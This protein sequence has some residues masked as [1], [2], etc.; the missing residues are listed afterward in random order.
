MGDLPAQ[1]RNRDFF[2]YGF[3]AVEDACGRPIAGRVLMHLNAAFG[4]P[5]RH[6]AEL[7]PVLGGR[8]IRQS[9]RGSVIDA[10]GQRLPDATITEHI[11]T[12]IHWREHRQ[13]LEIVKR[14]LAVRG[15]MERD[16]QR[17]FALRP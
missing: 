17:H 14:I 1:A 7:L 15:N 4:R 3:E 9:D 6:G 13:R 16:T 10:L 8:V 2:V 11:V 5:F 12:E